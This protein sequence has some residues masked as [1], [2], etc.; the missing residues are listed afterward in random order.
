MLG[1]IEY[2]FCTK[3]KVLYYPHSCY[4]PSM[5]KTCVA[6]NC[7]KPVHA[8]NACNTHYW[9][10]K[11]R[12]NI[13]HKKTFTPKSCSIKKCQNVSKT[14][15][16]CEIHYDRWRR[17]G[18]PKFKTRSSERHA[19]SKSLEY[20]KW[21]SMKVRCAEYSKKAYPGHAGKGVKICQR[22]LDS[23]S[24][25]Y[26]DMGPIPS[27]SHSIDRIDNDGCYEP[28]NCR[29]A[30][31]SQQSINKGLYANNTSGYRGVFRSGKR[32]TA[33][34]G[35]NSKIH[36]L[37]RFESAQEAAHAYNTAAIVYHGSDAKLNIIASETI[38]YPA[39]L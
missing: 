26:D 3:C 24:N 8:K 2:I 11:N 9:R 10:L 22:W 14:R 31:K 25:F 4:N 6:M 13:N 19:M 15:S 37:G 16:W 30:T 18:D 17:Y 20:I 33:G 38:E 21:S 39:E 29:W 32:W 28:G 27:P 5:A 23:F 34:V 35:L 36:W 1:R 12:G 7:S